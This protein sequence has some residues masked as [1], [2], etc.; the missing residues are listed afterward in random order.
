[1]LITLA[2]GMTAK[3][4]L[5]SNTNAITPVV[6]NTDKL[7]QLA[8]F[9]QQA[10]AEEQ[11]ATSNHPFRNIRIGIG[12]GIPYG[13]IGANF[14]IDPNDYLGLTAGL[15]ISPV[16]ADPGWVFGGRF[17]LSEREAT[18]RF[19]LT[20]LHGIVG[21]VTNETSSDKTGYEK[22]IVGNALGIGLNYEPEGSKWSC[23][24]DLM[25]PNFKVSERLKRGIAVQ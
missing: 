3:S 13:V 6:N 5:L 18:T 1:M 8:L 22:A 7:Q 17:Y 25:F 23:D 15:G 20:L 10:G 4:N 24:F 9:G 19:R 12:V 11:T 21:F 2:M 14:E 16:S